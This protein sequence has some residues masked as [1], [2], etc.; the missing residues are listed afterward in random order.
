MLSADEAAAA[1]WAEDL[2][3]DRTRDS[4][5]DELSMVLDLSRALL[6]A[7]TDPQPTKRPDLYVVVPDDR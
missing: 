1:D 3:Q 5:V 4:L 2:P 7:L 6:K